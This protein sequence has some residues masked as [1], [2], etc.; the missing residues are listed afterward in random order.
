MSVSLTLIPFFE[1]GVDMFCNYY[2]KSIPD[3]NMIIDNNTQELN[4]GPITLDDPPWLRQWTSQDQRKT[5]AAVMASL[6]G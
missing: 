5:A 3:Q 1:C 6:R 4:S 2:E